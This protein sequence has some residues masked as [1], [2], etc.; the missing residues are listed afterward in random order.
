MPPAVVLEK[1]QTQETAAS[2]KQG[3]VAR[4]VIERMVKRETAS[5]KWCNE[6]P[7][8]SSLLLL[9]ARQAITFGLVTISWMVFRVENMALFS[10]LVHSMFVWT[11]PCTLTNGA[12]LAVGVILFGWALQLWDKDKFQK[13]LINLPLPVKGLAY[14]GLSVLILACASEVAKPFIYIQV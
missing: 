3:S 14:A 11:V 8:A 1:K 10:Q 4:N 6:G 7:K 5:D 13:V 9:F 12:L 2:K